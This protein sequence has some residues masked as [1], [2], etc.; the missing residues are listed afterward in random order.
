[1]NTAKKLITAIVLAVLTLGGV[2]LTSQPASAITGAVR[3][4][5]PTRSASPVGFTAVRYVSATRVHVRFNT[6]SLWSVP[7]CQH[8]DSSNC[9]WDAQRRGN[10]LGRSWVHLN[11][12]VYYRA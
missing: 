11:G 12:K 5:A 8:E 9:Y 6:G 4:E 7:T 10:G 2:A 3:L 1:M